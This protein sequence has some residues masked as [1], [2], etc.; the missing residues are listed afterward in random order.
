MKNKVTNVHAEINSFIFLHLYKNIKYFKKHNMFRVF[1]KAQLKSKLIVSPAHSALSQFFEYR[2]IFYIILRKNK[3][4]GFFIYKNLFRQSGYFF[5]YKV[6][7]NLLIGYNFNI[8]NADYN[9]YNILYNIF[10]DKEYNKVGKV[11]LFFPYKPQSLDLN[12]FF[13]YNVHINN[14]LELYKINIYLFLKNLY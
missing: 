14:V 4:D 9:K 8:I 12:L 7:K 3:L 5:D 13:L 6:N 11:K 2:S 1:V 10:S